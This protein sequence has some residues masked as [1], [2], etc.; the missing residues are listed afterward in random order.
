MLGT[1]V[2]RRVTKVII[3][4]VNLVVRMVAG[5][6]WF[7]PLA[8][9]YHQGRRTG[10]WYVTP[11]GVAQV[12]DGFAIGWSFGNHS[13]WYRNVQGAGGCKL[14]WRGTDYQ[15]KEPEIVDKERAWGAFPGALK[16]LYQGLNVDEFV[17][18]HKVK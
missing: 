3:K 4:P 18:L 9:V 12:E 17:L 5:R 2:G 6:G 1:S 7:P 14:R 10:N 16:L 13:Q 15:L 8:L 11:T